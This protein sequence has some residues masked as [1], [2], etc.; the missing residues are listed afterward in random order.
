M[1]IDLKDLNASELDLLVQEIEARKA[2][3]AKT[4]KANALAEILEVLK[5]YALTVEDILPLLQKKS[6]K[7]VSK[8]AAKYANPD[9]PAQTWT[10]RG[11]K[12]AWLHEAIEAGKSIEDL[13]I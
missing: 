4:A 7:P 12:P 11:R 6:G 1:P 13:E 2:E 5:K 8:A 9:D 10:G 3:I